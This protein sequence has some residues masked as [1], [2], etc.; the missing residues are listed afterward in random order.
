MSPEKAPITFVL[1]IRHFQCQRKLLCLFCLIVQ[2]FTEIIVEAI[3]SGQA[4]L[5][6][7]CN[8]R[9]FF[10]EQSNSH[11]KKPYSEHFYSG[12]NFFGT[13]WKVQAKFTSLWPTCYIFC[14]KIEIKH[15]PIL[16]YFHLTHL[17]DFASS[18]LYNFLLH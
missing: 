4:K 11:R 5:Q 2:I 15:Y 17:F 18:E 10:V 8:S 3:Y 12:H 7:S 1:M 13:T 9:L 16:K 14:G 6:T